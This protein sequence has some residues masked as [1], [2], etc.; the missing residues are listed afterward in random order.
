MQQDLKLQKV[1]A[2]AEN[3]VIQGLIQTCSDKVGIDETSQSSKEL[4]V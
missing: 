4:N 2:M 3:S 1:I